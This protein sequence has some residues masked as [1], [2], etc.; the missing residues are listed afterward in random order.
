MKPRPTTIQP[1][2]THWNPNTKCDIDWFAKDF[3]K[4]VAFDPV[5]GWVGSPVIN[6]DFYRALIPVNELMAQ[7]PKWNG[8]GWPPVGTECEVTHKG[9]NGQWRRVRVCSG[10]I[11]FDAYEYPRVAMV[12]LQ[13]DAYSKRGEPW[14]LGNATDRDV[15]FRPFKSERE[16]AI[17][18]MVAVWKPTMGRFAEEKRGLAEM[19]YDAGY[20][21]VEK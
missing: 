14:F 8:E 5:N 10:L 6:I 11:E 17:D 12:S 15:K 3:G 13:D 20:R 9:L 2:A 7:L 1:G 4:W 19:L 18:E 16:K 21:K